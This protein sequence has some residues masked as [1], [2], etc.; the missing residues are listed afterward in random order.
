MIAGEPAGHLPSATTMSL[1]KTS[2][3]SRG[4]RSA[5]S[6]DRHI[7]ALVTDHYPFIWRLLR[8]LGLSAPDA[9]DAAQQVFMILARKIETVPEERARSFLYATAVRVASNH[10]RGLRRRP[11]LVGGVE[12][13]H[14]SP[15]D[16]PERRLAL[17]EA[18]K[19]LDDL[20]A[21]LPEPVRRVLVLAE[22]EQLGMSEVAALEKIPPGTAASRLRRGRQLFSELL[23]AASHRHALGRSR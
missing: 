10:R 23:S 3:D 8:R 18:C 1:A 19:L 13:G 22:V 6:Q 5:G 4:S 2:V 16:D 15:A 11:E 12:R 17:K 9:E 21:E 14:P 20:L 7:E